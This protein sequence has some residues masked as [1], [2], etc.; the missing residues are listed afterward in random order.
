[1]KK[2]LFFIGLELLAQS[3]GVASTISLRTCLLRTFPTRNGVGK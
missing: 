2:Y 3:S 1:M